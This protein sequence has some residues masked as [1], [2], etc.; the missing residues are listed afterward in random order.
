MDWHNFKKQFENELTDNILNYW[1]KE[2][3]DTNRKTFFGRITN[4][5]EKFPEAPLSAVFTTRVLWTFSAAYRF[6]P[7]AIYKKMADEAFR[8]LL[9]TFWDNDNGGIYWSVFPDGKPEDMKK[10]FYA[11]A[12]FI[13]ALSEYWLAFKDEKAKQL[14]ISMFMLME[15]YAF[16]PEFGG[17]IEANTA[18]WKETDDQ[19][20]SPKDLDVKK[21]MNTHLHILEAYTNLYR[22]HKV[23]DV[24]KK[25]AH[26]LHIFLD[27]ILDEET[28]HLILFFD[29][30]WTVRSEIDSYG[31][32]IEATW[33]M[34]E[35][36]EVL[37]NKE[38]IEEVEQV[39]VKMSD[40]SIK[41]GLAPH[42]GMYY[43]KAEG[44][45]QEQFDWWPQAEAVVGFFNTYQITK[46]EKYLEHV[47][48]SWKFIQDHIM[49]KKNG[50]WFWGVDSNL[51]PLKTDKVSPWKAPYHNGRMCM[52]M[53]RRIGMIGK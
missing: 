51:E 41:E 45:L 34:H 18:D 44:H 12:F 3:Y 49:D 22:I 53:M 42:G 37:G 28:G 7:T 1:V 24:E 35:A 26:L 8:I 31:H 30:D 5:G 20:L 21:S 16:D 29:K 46:D 43:E 17:Y 9:E 13:Y 47:Q 32:D 14:A 23:E 11:E 6:Y 48:K 19:R 36:A 4:E 50:E 25:V 52:E 33:L 10:Q 40:V 39:A 15:K 38:L 27:K 2:V